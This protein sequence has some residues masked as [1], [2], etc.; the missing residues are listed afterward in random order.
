M[1][2]RNAS[3][4]TRTN[5]AWRFGGAI[6]VGGGLLSSAGAVVFTFVSAAPGSGMTILA[7]LFEG[8]AYVLVAIGYRGMGVSGWAQTLIII[9]GAI[10]VLY[11]LSSVSEDF[12]P[13]LPD[14]LLAILAIGA[15]LAVGVGAVAVYGSVDREGAPT[16]SLIPVG[17]VFLLIGL[18]QL[19]GLGGW[20]LL[21]I[22]GVLYLVTGIR[23]LRTSSRNNVATTK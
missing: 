19:F 11:A 18:L 2:D 13:A 17:A 12:V 9:G 8:I 3:V 21:A 14:L 7:L 1:H 22:L 16:A 20:W 10:D 4:M 15:A 6:F 5:V 23:F